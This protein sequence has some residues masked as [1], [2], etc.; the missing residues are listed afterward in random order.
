[1]SVA[2]TVAVWF[3]VIDPVV[4][5]K[6]A[7]VLFAGT[8]TEAGTCSPAEVEL[9]ET[10]APLLPAAIFKETVHVAAVEEVNVAGLQVTLL[11]AGRIPPEPTVMEP[12]VAERVTPSP[13][14]EEP[15]ASAIPIAAVGVPEAR[16]TATFATA[17]SAMIPEFSPEAIQV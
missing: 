8:V 16:V 11:N 14:M 15:M 3:A 7:V 12:P 1:L 6:V 17:P 10:A 13:S 2:V 4:A 9:R 5:W